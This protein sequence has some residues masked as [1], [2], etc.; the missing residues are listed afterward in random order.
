MTNAASNP[1]ISPPTPGAGSSRSP[2]GT[3]ISSRAII[4][5]I[6]NTGMRRGME[7]GRRRDDRDDRLSTPMHEATDTL[8]PLTHNLLK[9]RP[10]AYAR[11]VVSGAGNDDA[12]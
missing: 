2:T 12:R 4:R 6:R 9:L 3:S 10:D 1:P 7:W 5:S 11:L 8:S